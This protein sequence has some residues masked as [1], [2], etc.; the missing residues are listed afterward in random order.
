LQKRVIR[1]LLIINLENSFRKSL[2]IFWK[3]QT[4]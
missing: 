3:Y 2:Y 1:K 4:I